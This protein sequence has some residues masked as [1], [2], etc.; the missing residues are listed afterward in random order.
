[1]LDSILNNALIDSEQ[2]DI[3]GSAGAFSGIVVKID[4]EWVLLKTAMVDDEDNCA[5][6]A[7]WAIRK[8]TIDSVCRTIANHDL[9]EFKDGLEARVN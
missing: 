4:P 6:I 7:E 9:T 1:M 2:I 8:S 5:Y 3:F